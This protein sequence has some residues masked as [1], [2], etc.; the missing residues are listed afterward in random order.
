MGK[1]I[2]IRDDIPSQTNADHDGI[3]YA[4]F[5][6]SFWRGVWRASILTTILVLVVFMSLITIC[7]WQ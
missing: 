5:W 6:P 1:V 4:G 7:I 3:V 2:P